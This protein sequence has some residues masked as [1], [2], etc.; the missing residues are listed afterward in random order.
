MSDQTHVDLPLNNRHILIASS[1]KVS[2]KLSRGLEDL[3]GDITVFPVIAIRGI[4]GSREL[5]D[6]AAKLGQYDWVIFTSAYGVDY[7]LQFLT[8]KGISRQDLHRG[9][10]CAVGPATA[11]RLDHF[12]IPV[13]LI[14][15][16]YVGEGILSALQVRHSE[17]AGLKDLRILIPRAKRARNLLPQELAKSGA[18]VDTVA[19]YESILPPLAE[20]DKRSILKQKPDLIIFTSSSTVSN[21]FELLGPE[22]SERMLRRTPVAVLGPITAATASSFGKRPAIVPDKSTTAHL[23]EAIL[24]FF[25]EA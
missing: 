21:F 20:E 17:P 19:C 25:K 5:E 13:D 22:D 2:T 16:D 6:S 24:Q 14:P 1:A 3:G 11:A 8:R 7:Y 12:D 10:I 9:K 15:E 18:L 23:I 4:P